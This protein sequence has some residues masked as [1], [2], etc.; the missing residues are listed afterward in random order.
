[1]AKETLTMAGAVAKLREQE[2]VESLLVLL[3][4]TVAQD[5]L[6]KVALAW[7]KVRVSYLDE[8]A[9]FTDGP[10]LWQDLWNNTTV[11]VPSLVATTGIQKC[12]HFVNI[13]KGYHLIYP[14]GTLST[15]TQKALRQL[16]KAE[17][18]L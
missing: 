13:L 1:M 11:D 18:G 17:L 6:R 16:A 7:P 5:N 9:R 3:G 10:N 4:R 12:L 2:D 8:R 14:D 15:N